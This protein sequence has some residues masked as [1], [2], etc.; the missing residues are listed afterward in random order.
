ATLADEDA[1]RAYQTI[2]ALVGSPVQAVPLVKE[3]LQ[4]VSKPK[5]RA[6]TCWIAELDSDQ[7]AVRQNARAELEKLGEQAEA[8]L[9]TKLAEKPSLEVRQQ[10]EQLLTKIEH[11]SESLRALRAVEVLERIGNP[12]AKT[13]LETLATGT[14]GARLTKAAKESLARLNRLATAAKP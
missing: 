11:S 3:R 13:V 8:A 10:I 14:E 5:I 6:V 2:G 12:E 1:T 4:P 7:F 9:R